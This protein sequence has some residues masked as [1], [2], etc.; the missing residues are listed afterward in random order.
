MEAARR[1]MVGEVG[2]DEPL[3][4]FVFRCPPSATTFSWEIRRF[5]AIVVKRSDHVFASEAAAR[6][7]GTAAL[8]HIAGPD[9]L[10]R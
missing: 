6:E 10:K 1:A 7:A 2:A 9:P 5:G 3:R 8:A 4:V